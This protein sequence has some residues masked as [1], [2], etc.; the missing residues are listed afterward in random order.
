MSA[1]GENGWGAPPEDVLTPM[2][3][4]G[5]VSKWLAELK[6]KPTEWGW[7][8]YD[9]YDSAR[10]SSYRIQRRGFEVRIS[11]DGKMYAR[12]PVPPVPTP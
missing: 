10:G 1:R 6:S 4:L 7:R 11:K 9:S 12:W 2:S 5:S 8:Q 3:R